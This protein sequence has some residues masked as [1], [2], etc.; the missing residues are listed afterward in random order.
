[1]IT[2]GHRLH[3]S[4]LPQRGWPLSPLSSHREFSAPGTGAFPI[5]CLAG[6]GQEGCCEH[7]TMSS[8]GLP[9]PGWLGHLCLQEGSLPGLPTH[10]WWSFLVWCQTYG[11][12]GQTPWVLIQPRHSLDRS[13]GICAAFNWTEL[14]SFVCGGRGGRRSFSWASHVPSPGLSFLHWQKKGWCSR[15]PSSCLSP[16]QVGSAL[17]LPCEHWTTPVIR[18]AVYVTRHTM[19]TRHGTQQFCT[20]TSPGISFNPRTSQWCYLCS[21]SSIDEET[22]G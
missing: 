12:P 7:R 20:S 14:R 13:H 2:L 9:L 11:S 5:T 21:L 4:V 3:S 15:C 18:A 16:A 1:M 6:S 22:E 17:G 10:V 19:H 8:A